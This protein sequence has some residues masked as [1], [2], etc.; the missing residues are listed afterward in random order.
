MAS[1]AVMLTT[2]LLCTATNK[3]PC[4]H[5]GMKQSPTAVLMSI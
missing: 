5:G 2:G 3:V 4:T 1:V